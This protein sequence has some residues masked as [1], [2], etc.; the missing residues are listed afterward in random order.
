MPGRVVAVV[1]DDR[2]TGDL[3]LVEAAGGQVVGRREGPQ[4]LPDVVQR[5][6][7]GE[8]RG[9]GGQGV[10]DVHPGP[11]AERRGQQ[12]GPGEL[13]LA[14]AVPDHDHL[15]ALGRLEHER[16]AA[17][18]AVIVDHVG[19][20]GAGLGHRE[21]DDLARAAAA[22]AAHQ[23]VVGVEHREAVAGHRLDDDR[24]D[25]GE[26]LEGVDAAQPEVVGLRR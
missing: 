19:D 23:R 2:D 8:R 18:P 12:V 4:A 6:T 16:L 26:L 22:H 3:D 7:G 15:A 14:P 21:P 10:L 24:L 25:L 5:C 20:L 9:R 13:H 11:A 17:A 1:D